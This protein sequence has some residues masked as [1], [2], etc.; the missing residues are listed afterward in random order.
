MKKLLVILAVILMSTWIGIANA[1]CPN[2]QPFCPDVQGDINQTGDYNLT[3]DLTVTVPE[4]LTN[5]ALTGGTSW[6]RSGDFALTTNTAVYTDSGGS[7]ELFQLAADMAVTVVGDT[8]YELTYTVSSSSGAGSFSL[9]ATNGLVGTDILLWSSTAG[10]GIDGTYRARFTT[11]TTPGDFRISASTTTADF[12]LDN[13]SLKRS[14][15]QSGDN[16]A[17]IGENRYQL[18]IANATDEASKT[19]EVNTVNNQTGLADWHVVMIKMKTD[20]TAMMPVV[21]LSNI[22]EEDESLWQNEIHSGTAFFGAEVKHKNS[23]AGVTST[24]YRDYEGDSTDLVTNTVS[25]VFLGRMILQD[26]HYDLNGEIPVSVFS[27]AVLGDSSDASVVEAENVAVFVGRVDGTSGSNTTIKHGSGVYIRNH[28]GTITHAYGM[29]LEDQTNA[30]K[31]NYGIVLE[32][33]EDCVWFDGVA[34]VGMCSKT[35]VISA[36]DVNT[37]NATPVVLATGRADTIIEVVSAIITYDYDAVYVDGG[38]FVLEY[39]NNTDISAVVS[40][41][42]FIDQTDD[43]MRYIVPIAATYTTN[44]DLEPFINQ[45]IEL[46]NDGA[47]HSGGTAASAGAGMSNCIDAA[48]RVTSGTHGQADG[49][50]LVFDTTEC[51]ITAGTIYWVCEKATSQFSLDKVQ[52]CG[53]NSDCA[54]GSDDCIDRLNVTDAT[55]S[56]DYTSQSVVTIKLTYRLHVLGL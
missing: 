50:P 7:G 46:T 37:L 8:S 18:Y 31:A 28:T 12:T 21:V 9:E 13:I 15:I 36:A 11:K 43:E 54:A 3:G 16:I 39:E 32:D 29:R 27:G 6:D 5:G 20:N 42:N 2:Q 33:G 24:V 51:G 49:T 19:F 1:T 4:T 48:D 30:T 25:T 45:N 34:G 10:P 35:T 56:G 44:L 17:L 22:A 41:L 26:G 38:D 52:G 14:A 23:T 47:E 40:S 53:V 55:P